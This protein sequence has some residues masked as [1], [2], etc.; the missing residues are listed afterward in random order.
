MADPRQ[1]GGIPGL[2]GR[3]GSGRRTEGHLRLGRTLYTL[4]DIKAGAVSLETAKKLAQNPP[5]AYLATLFLGLAESAAG[6]ADRAERLYAEAIALYP[7]A[8]SAQVAMSE[9][10]YMTGHTDDAAFRMTVLLAAR[11]KDDP[12]WTYVTGEHW[13]LGTRLVMLRLSA[14]Q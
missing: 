2:G 10:S 8:Q 7:R 14:R 3:T 5:V 13:H 6:H 11:D 4:G 9:L 12:W 1:T